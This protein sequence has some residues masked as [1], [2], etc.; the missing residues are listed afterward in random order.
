MNSPEYRHGFLAVPFS[1]TP[2]S[3]LENWHR[4]ELNLY[5]LLTHPEL[6]V[7]TVSGVDNDQVIA[8]GDIFVAHGDDSLDENLKAL[9]TG[10]YDTLD[11]RT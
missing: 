11:N 6:P 10:E 7:H 5:A 3:Y 8:I 4:I 9:L 1:Q 2:P